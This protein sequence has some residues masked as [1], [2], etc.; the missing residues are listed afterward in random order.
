MKLLID[1]LKSF[2]IYDFKLLPYLVS[3]LILTAL[4]YYSYEHNLYI[5]IIRT[6]SIYLKSFYILSLFSLPYLLV[7]FLK[8]KGNIRAFY[9]IN[10]F[11]FLSII[12]IF[13]LINA[14]TKGHIY[15]FTSYIANRKEYIEWLFIINIS[16]HKFI[17]LSLPALIYYLI[18]TDKNVFGFKV[19]DV[20]LKI[21]FYMLLIMLIPIIIASYSNS[22]LDVYPRYKPG[23]LENSGIM[24]KF[25]TIAAVESFYGLRF[26]GV[27]L[28]FRGL[29]IIG[30]IRIIGKHAVLPSA[31]L[32]SIWHFGK[33][34]GEAIGAFF[35][36]YILGVLAYKTKSIAGGVI[37][38]LGIALLMELFAYLQLFDIL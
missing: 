13:L 5:T 8:L 31:V 28:F 21:Y 12:F 6:Q 23:I 27:E 32:Y 2:L 1:Y 22:F 19:K 15:L 9:N 26:I 14:L 16:L 34:M 38:H 11:I 24:T 36:A 20:N 35:G 18:F 33:P 29:M 30:A 10:T 37:L 17:I 7:L 3:I 4:F 25:Q